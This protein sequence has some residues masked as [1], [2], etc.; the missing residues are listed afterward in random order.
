MFKKVCALVLAPLAMLLGFMSQAH[1]VIDVT[2]VTAGITDAQTAVLAIIGA[3]LTLSIAIFGIVK[4]YNFVS[5]K[6]GA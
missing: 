3:L 6:A 4:V 1:A 2:G 5:K